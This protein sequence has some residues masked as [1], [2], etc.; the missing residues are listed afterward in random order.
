MDVRNEPVYVQVGRHGDRKPR[1]TN[2]RRLPDNIPRMEPTHLAAH[3]ANNRKHSEALL[4]QCRTEGCYSLV[5][6]NFAKR[7]ANTRMRSDDTATADF[8]DG[9]GCSLCRS[10]G[11]TKSDRT[12]VRNR[13]MSVLRGHALVIQW[14]CRGADHTL[15]RSQRPRLGRHPRGAVVALPSSAAN[16]AAEHAL[17]YAGADRQAARRQ[18]IADVT[19][20]GVTFFLTE[21]AEPPSTHELQPS[22]RPLSIRDTSRRPPGPPPADQAHCHQ[23]FHRPAL[24]QGK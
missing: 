6:F 11:N 14:P 2:Q 17:S 9:D 3:L 21:L 20:D 8:V 7:K 18:A 12:V 23:L 15:P 19:V 16:L 1:F 4:L 13:A 22:C 24:T 5:S 10:G